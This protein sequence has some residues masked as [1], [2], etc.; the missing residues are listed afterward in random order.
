VSAVPAFDVRAPEVEKIRS[1]VTSA[2]KLRGFMLAKLPLALF[3]GL[4]VTELTADACSVTVPY[5]WRTQNPFRSTYFAAQSMAAEMSTGALGL[6]LVQ[7][8]PVSVAMLIVGMTAEFTK[9]ADKLVT[10]RCTDGPAVA[11]AFQHTLD[12]GEPVKVTTTTVGTMPDG[13]IVSTFTF[14]WSFKRRS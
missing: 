11:K 4:R 7:A 10:F 9:K 12:T 1:Q 2:W 13:T 5:G 8:A 6:S 14:T 3:A